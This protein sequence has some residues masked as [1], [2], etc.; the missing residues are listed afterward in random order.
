[1][2]QCLQHRETELLAL[3][4]NT[5]KAEEASAG[6][7]AMQLAAA[8]TSEVRNYSEILAILHSEGNKV[9]ALRQMKALESATELQ[10]DWELPAQGLSVKIL[11]EK[12]RRIISETAAV[13]IV[14]SEEATARRTSITRALK[15]RYTGERLDA[16]SFTVSCDVYLT[17]VS[18]C[19]PYKCGELAYINSFCTLKGD[20]TDSPAVYK[21]RSRETMQ[22]NAESSVFKL[23]LAS[24]LLLSR[25]QVYSVVFCIQ[26]ASTY[27]CVECYPELEVPGI[28]WKF[29]HTTFA[30]GHLNN[31]CDVMCG[32]IADFSY[33]II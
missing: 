5:H 17:A 28:K 18:V 30:P 29:L 4:E 16:L 26:G 10:S 24:P 13:Q 14:N 25:R 19:R 31:R 12:L 1:M 7:A 32:P 6:D 8:E 23:Q 33:I 27:K 21:H 9:R 15:W 22:Y 2:K 20:R 3:Y 11:E